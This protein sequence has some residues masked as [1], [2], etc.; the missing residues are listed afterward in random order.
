MSE[1]YNVPTE[2]TAVKP[3][4]LVVEDEPVI[5][6]FLADILTE[7]GFEVDTAATVNESLTLA[8]RHGPFSI[9]FI[10]L[11]LPDRTGLELMS[12]LRMMHPDVPIVIASA[13]GSMASRDIV[14]GRNHPPVLCKPYAREEITKVLSALGFS[15]SKLS[16]S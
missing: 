9:A 10:D 1:A 15:P 8:R 6:M 12:D 4:A 2:F 7:L 13:Y 11:S 16:A 3:S 5:A 14:E